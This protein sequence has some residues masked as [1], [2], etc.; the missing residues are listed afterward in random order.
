MSTISPQAR[1][2]LVAA[3]T[4][5]YQRSTPAERGRILD[6][7][8]ALTGY[9]RKHAIRVL[10][11]SSAV[12]AVR[13]GRRSVY[14]EAVTEGLVVLWE[15]SD[16]VC[17]KRLKALLPTLV[18]ALE[19]HGHVTLD[20]PGTRATDGGERR[21]DRPPPGV[22]EGGD[23]WS[24]PAPSFRGRQRTGQ[25]SGAHVRRLAGSGAGLRR[26]RPRRALWIVDGWQ[27]RLD[28]GADRYRQRLDGMRTAARACSRRRGRRGGSAPRRP[29][30]SVAGDRHR[31]RQRVSQR[32]VD[33]LLQGARHRANPYAKA[34]HFRR[35]AD[36]G[37]AAGSADGPGIP[38]D[39]RP[40]GGDA[41]A[42]RAIAQ[43]FGVDDHTVAKAIRWF[44][45]EL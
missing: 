19:R 7:F 32:G 22:R 3:V 11:G 45:R 10:N 13:R 40:G 8:V 17:G 9:H 6:E 31:Q 41:S 1:Q 38:A 23:G 4:E 27:L 28:A 42:F 15:A 20:P 21:H 30:V 16:R 12:S 2:E 14:D 35:A 25:G 29:P 5:R 36:R 43:H 26:G 24:A 33:R 39:R 34:S 37:R 18:P 44:H